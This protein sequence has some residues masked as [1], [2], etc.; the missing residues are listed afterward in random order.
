MRSLRGKIVVVSGL[1]AGL[2]GNA[3]ASATLPSTGVEVEGLISA[4]ITA[5][6]AVAAV[7]VGGYIAFKVIKKALG[8]TGRALG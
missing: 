2:C 8:W 4:G 6:G 3:F 5:M 7:A 1:T